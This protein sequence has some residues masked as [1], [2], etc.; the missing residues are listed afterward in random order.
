MPTNQNLILDNVSSQINANPAELTPEQ[1]LMV[2]QKSNDTPSTA[3]M[4][5]PDQCGTTNGS[6]YPKN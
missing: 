6:E 1:D 4:E 3:V 5:S 2:R